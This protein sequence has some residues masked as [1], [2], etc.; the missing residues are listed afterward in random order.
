MDAITENTET[1]HNSDVKVALAHTSGRSSPPPNC[2]ICMDTCNN[3]SYTDS[4]LHE[5]CFNCIVTWSKVK[6][7][8]PL[9]KQSFTSIIHNVVSNEQYDEYPVRRQFS[10]IE[11]LNIENFQT[12]RYRY[13]TTLTFPRRE[14]V[15]A[16]Q[17]LLLESYRA[18]SYTEPVV[19]RSTIAVRRNV[20]R[21]NMW[22]QPMP[23]FYGRFRDCSPQHYRYNEAQVHRLVPWINRELNYLLNYNN[24]HINYV[25]TKIIAIITRL[26]ITSQGFIDELHCYFGCQTEHF[27]HEL[28]VFASSPLD[29]DDYD[30]C[31]EYTSRQ[32]ALRLRG[33]HALPQCQH[34]DT[35]SDVVFLDTPT[36]ET[37]ENT[38]TPVP[39]PLIDLTTLPSQNLPIETITYSS[40]D[41]DDVML[42][43]YLK[44]P[45]ERTPEIVDLLVSDADSDVVVQEADSTET[46]QKPHE[47]NLVKVTLKGVGPMPVDKEN[48]PS[49]RRQILHDRSNGDSTSDYA[50]SDYISSDS[51]E[52]QVINTRKRRY[53][54]KSKSKSKKRKVTD[55]RLKKKARSPKDVKSSKKRLESTN[56]VP[57]LEPQISISGTTSPQAGPSGLQPPSRRLR[58]VVNV[59]H[60]TRSRPNDLSQSDTDDD[61]PLALC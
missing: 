42:V 40:D 44:P 29:L 13:R 34:S 57:E 50:P 20:Y 2:V 39:A 5:F 37:S 54:K 9:C 47:A 30:R 18:L 7:V 60:N 28:Y 8:C 12:R 49:A 14:S 41:D 4:C 3:K 53:V 6:A 17:R 24:G 23:D 19:R 58:S 11:G 56:V 61:I 26:A 16:L 55:S 52:S 46:E 31:V 35:D 45:H 36:A 38:S 27:A 1:A 59:M 43:G 22:A 48:E 33:R 32:E 10:G 15:V 25:I 51:T 21:N